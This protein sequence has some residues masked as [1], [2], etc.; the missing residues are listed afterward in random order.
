MDKR[1]L[2]FSCGLDSFISDW[3]LKQNGLEYKRVYFNLRSIYSNCELEFFRMMYDPLYTKVDNS[4]DISY[5][6]KDDLYVPNRNLLMAVMAQGTYDADVIYLSGVKDDRVADQSEKFY[7]K[8]GEVLT[9]SIGREVNVKSLLFDKEKSEWCKY[10]AEHEEDK[11][12]LLTHTY[13]CFSPK[14]QHRDLNIWEKDANGNFQRGE[15]IT[16]FGCLKCPAC[17]RRLC[18]LTSINIFTPFLDPKLVNGYTD[19][20]DKKIYP[21]R[22]RTAVDYANFINFLVRSINLLKKSK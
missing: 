12:W 7:L 4:I 6:E 14:F 10:F 15:M 2:L 17:Y 21:N 22:Y 19:K 13:S 8:A 5:I 20:I 16:L 3:I 11:Y 18:S 9:E 1:V